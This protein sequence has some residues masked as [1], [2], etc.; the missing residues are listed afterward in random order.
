MLLL[1]AS[2]SR[3]APISGPAFARRQIGSWHP[4]YPTPPDQPT[5]LPPAVPQKRIIACTAAPLVR[6]LPLS[7]VASQEDSLGTDAGHGHTTSLAA[8]RTCARRSRSR[9]DGSVRPAY[10]FAGS[11]SGAPSLGGA[12]GEGLEVRLCQHPRDS[13]SGHPQ[14]G[15]CVVSQVRRPKVTD[16]PLL[17]FRLFHYV[18]LALRGKAQGFPDGVTRWSSTRSFNQHNLSLGLLLTRFYRPFSRIYKQ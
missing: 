15:I 14:V 3:Q 8:P 18:M 11:S 5:L 12:S 7:G 4:Y 17:S 1:R 10:R 2:Q 6:A 13:K 16:N 9:L